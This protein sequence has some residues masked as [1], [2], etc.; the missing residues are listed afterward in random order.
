MPGAQH[1][2]DLAQVGALHVDEAV[3]QVQLHIQARVTGEEV[4]NRRCQMS[5]T[6]SRWR[7]N[8]DQPLG[9]VAQGHGLGAGQAQF[10]DDP[11]GP[12][13]E[14]QT[15]GR[16]PD[17]M[18]AANEQAAADRTF[19]AVDPPRHGGRGQRVEAGGG[20]K[21]AGFQDIQKQAEL[22]GQRLGIHRYLLV[23]DWH[24]HCALLCVSAL[25]RTA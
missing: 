2:V 6:E 24:S 19:Q 18:G 25:E 3:D 1:Q 5:A 4:G 16:G 23:R 21:A 20:G 7:V 17:R 14:R 9:S 8:P 13:G 22:I 10:G 15:G 11:P 12:F